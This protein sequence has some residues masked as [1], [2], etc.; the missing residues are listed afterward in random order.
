MLGIHK[1]VHPFQSDPSHR[2]E[3]LTK[4]MYRRSEY[5]LKWNVTL[6]ATQFSRL[7]GREWIIDYMH[8]QYQ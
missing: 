4:N 7:F 3:N 8:D 2:V 5:G 1:G 6:K